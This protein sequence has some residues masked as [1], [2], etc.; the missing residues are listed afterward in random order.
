MADRVNNYTQTKFTGSVNC[1]TCDS[2]CL[3]TY[4]H[5]NHTAIAR[6]ADQSVLVV[7]LGGV[8]A[9]LKLHA[10]KRNWRECSFASFVIVVVCALIITTSD[11]MIR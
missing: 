11:F 2:C 1:L 7:L 10:T 6:Y 9:V 8:G 3:Y 5:H 4:H